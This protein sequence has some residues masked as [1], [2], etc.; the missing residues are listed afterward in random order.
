[1]YVGIVNAAGVLGPVVAFICGGILLELY[2]HF[3]TIDTS[4][5]VPCTSRRFIN[6]QRGHI[7]LGKKIDIVTLKSVKNVGNTVEHI[8]LLYLAAPCCRGL[9]I[10]QLGTDIHYLSAFYFG[11]CGR[12]SWLNSQLSSAR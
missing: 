5:S 6:Q 11:S 4:T 8:V 7:T 1:M 12:L 2:T 9:D 10:F 3:D